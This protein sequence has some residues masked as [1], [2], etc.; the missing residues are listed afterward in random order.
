MSIKKAF[1][2]ITPTYT[3]KDDMLRKI[4]EKKDVAI[5]KQQRR[6]IINR[7]CV[8]SA[9]CF[10]V[11]ICMV[12]IGIFVNSTGKPISVSGDRNS[13][14][15]LNSNINS[16]P[17]SSKIDEN[18]SSVPET[19]P[20]TETT[21]I[22]NSNINSIPESS[23]IEENA[24]SVSETTTETGFKML[25]YSWDGYG[26]G[27]KEI[28]GDLGY[29]IID[30]LTKLQETGDVISEISKDVVNENS[31]RLPITSGTVWIDCGSVGLFRLNPE[32]TEICKVQT[33]LGEGKVLQMT[34]T[35]EELLGQAWYY[36]PYDFW[37]GTYENDAVTLRQIFKA[38]S[39]IEWIEIESM[40]IE[41][42][43]ESQNSI[44]L[45]IWANESKTV[46]AHFLSSRSSDDLGSFDTKEIELVK[47]EK[48]I[49][50]FTFRGFY[51][52]TYWAYITIDNTKI[53]LTINP[54]DSD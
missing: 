44:T 49:V 22:L 45:H 20:S 30:C 19:E 13:N 27:Q 51:D 29:A 42:E 17:E 48:T 47:G 26:V 38:D 40:Y 2:E 16:I 53:D 35:L 11:I 31:G 54:K 21:I 6:R 3:Q 25:R 15:V 34:D 33:H 28:K 18:A 43:L 32:M 14:P 7:F 37:S 24:S 9:A 1:D 39:A 8:A 36:Y 50:E 52:S 46:E 23:K 4:K 10:S 5:K 41:N 12:A